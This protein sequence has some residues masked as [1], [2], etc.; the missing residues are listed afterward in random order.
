MAVTANW[1]IGFEYRHYEFE[2]EDITP[3]SG[4][5]PVFDDR[6]TFSPTAD[7]L[8]ARLSYVFGAEREETP[9]LK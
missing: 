5:G 3:G 8:T 1:K 4:S 7:T 6:A 9:P 2:D